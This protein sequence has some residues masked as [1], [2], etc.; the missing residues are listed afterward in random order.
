MSAQPEKTKSASDTL[1]RAMERFGESEPKFAIVI[2]INEADE[3]HWLRSD[4]SAT[5]TVGVLESIKAQVLKDWL[6][7][8]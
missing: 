4:T 1:M 2:F 8:E 6:E 7:D 3:L 5:T